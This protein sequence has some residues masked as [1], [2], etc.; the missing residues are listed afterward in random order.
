MSARPRR[1]A[2]ADWRI[3]MPPHPAQR[4][5]PRHRRHDAAIP[6][7][8]CSKASSASSASRVKPPLISWGLMLQEPRNHSVIGSY[9]WILS[10]VGFVLVTVF[11]LQRARRRPARRHRPLL[12]PLMASDDRTQPPAAI[13]D[14]PSTPAISRCASR[15]RAAPSRRCATSRS[16]STAARPSRS[17]ASPAPASR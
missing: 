16:S 17:S 14:L 7:S 3:I 1:S 15:S 12:R 10:P 6:T 2:P 8:C 13:R 4:D 9:P 11:A 5:E